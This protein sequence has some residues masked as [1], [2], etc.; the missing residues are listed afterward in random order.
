MKD[1]KNI[2]FSIST[3][4]NFGFGR[5]EDVTNAW[6]TISILRDFARLD[7]LD[8]NPSDG[9]IIEIANVIS[10]IKSSRFFDYRLRRIAELKVI[11]KILK[12]N[13]LIN[14]DGIEYFASLIDMY[15][16][17]R[18]RRFAGSS[19]TFGLTPKYSIH[20]NFVGNEV[21]LKFYGLGFNIEYKKDKPINLFWQFDTKYALIVNYLHNSNSITNVKYS[22]INVYPKVSASLSYYPST[23][24]QMNSNIE[25]RYETLIFNDSDFNFDNSNFVFIWGNSV[26]YY[27][28]PKVR[29]E[30]LLKFMYGTSYYS[31]YTDLPRSVGY[32]NPFTIYSNIFNK[33]FGYRF[34]IK[35]NYSIF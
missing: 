15:Y 10:K 7:I 8:H 16:V 19:F 22:S 17:N 31:D 30:G 27:L 9:E 26:N 3:G 35:F 29:L 33:G 28:S 2:D 14:N 1:E 12:A 4:F 13:K 25:I 6:N 21:L 5:I 32:L 34:N 18:F 20:K 24:T 11:D 23:R